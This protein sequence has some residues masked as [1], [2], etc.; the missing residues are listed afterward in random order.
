LFLLELTSHT[1]R[2]KRGE[3]TWQKVDVGLLSFF[4]QYT[5]G[6]SFNFL[7]FI[8]LSLTLLIG[9]LSLANCSL[10]RSWLPNIFYIKKIVYIINQFLKPPRVHWEEKEEEKTFTREN[11]LRDAMFKLSMKKSFTKK[12][13][14]TQKIIL[15][16][17]ELRCTSQLLIVVLLFFVK[18]IKKFLSV[19]RVHWG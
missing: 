9:C 10:K 14:N 7:I 4:Y 2:R 13:K 17:F 6:L 5:K 3:R 1:R 11:A 12:K 8:F 15:G 16:E 19:F 18:S